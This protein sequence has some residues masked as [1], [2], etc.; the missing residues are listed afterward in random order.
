M[1]SLYIG[2]RDNEH[3]VTE[4]TLTTG[5]VATLTEDEA[6]ELCLHIDKNLY[7]NSNEALEAELQSMD[8]ENELLAEEL[9]ELKHKM[10]K[11]NTKYTSIERMVEILNTVNPN[12]N[13]KISIDILTSVR[14]LLDA[15]VTISSRVYNISIPRYT[16]VDYLAEELEKPLKGYSNYTITIN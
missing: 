8:E 15:T 12:I 2:S 13:P 7:L 3:H 1:N 14:H 6:D 5:K 10:T 11:Q 16:R 9:E 4:Y